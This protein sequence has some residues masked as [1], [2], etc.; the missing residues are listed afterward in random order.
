MLL[1]FIFSSDE[2]TR[3]VR[4]H[5]DVCCCDTT[6]RTNNEKKGLFTVAF[7][8][9]NKKPFNGARAYI[10]NEQR[11]MFH[12]LFKYCLP[13]F[14]GPSVRERMNLIMTDSCSEE[15]MS[16]IENTGDKTSGFPN[17]ILGLC[18]WHLAVSGQE[19]NI[20]GYVSRDGKIKKKINIPKFLKLKCLSYNFIIR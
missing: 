3:L 20:D 17:A 6:F 13:F 12:T 8:D 2:E 14:W 7:L 4:M 11:W 10:P 18:Y 1:I 16:V 9:G 19:R 15:F 5:S